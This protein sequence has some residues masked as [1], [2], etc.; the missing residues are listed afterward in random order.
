MYFKF[1]TCDRKSGEM[2]SPY[3]S[4]DKSIRKYKVYEK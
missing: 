1:T 3:K 4:D 2:N